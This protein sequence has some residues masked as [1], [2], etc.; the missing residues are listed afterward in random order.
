MLTGTFSYESGRMSFSLPPEVTV[1]QQHLEDGAVYLFRHQTLGEL[2]RIVVRDVAGGQCHI[3]SEVVGDAADPMTATRLKIFQPLSE[4]LTAA[5]DAAFASR[6]P[7][8]PVPPHP[9]VPAPDEVI[10][11]KMIP[12]DRCGAAAALLIFADTARTVGE[13]EDYARKMYSNYRQM[14]VPTWVIGAPLGIASDRTPSLVL[15]VWPERQPVR[16]LTPHAFNRELD[17]VLKQCC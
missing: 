16:K 13:V 12:C 8:T 11:S 3:S 7:A 6:G 1:Q 15:K 4:Q 9:P 5:L 10:A 2:G 14:N 17:A